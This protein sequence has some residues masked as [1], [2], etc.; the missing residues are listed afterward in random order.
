MATSRRWSR[1]EAE[2][3]ARRFAEAIRSRGAYAHIEVHARGV[4]L[5]VEN[6]DEQGAYPVAR[7]TALDSAQFGLSFRR[8]TGR[9]ETMPVVGTLDDVAE[10]LLAMLAPYLERVDFPVAISGTGH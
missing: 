9:W 5:V 1:I 7:A 10:A 8:H 4:H 3:A 2:A 6:S